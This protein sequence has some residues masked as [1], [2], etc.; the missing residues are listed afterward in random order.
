MLELLDFIAPQL[1]SHVIYS[2]TRPLAF[3]GPA[4]DAKIIHFTFI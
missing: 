1:R 3:I 2:S 4:K